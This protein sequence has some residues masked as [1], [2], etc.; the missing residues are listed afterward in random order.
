[1][2]LLELLSPLWYLFASNALLFG[3]ARNVYTGDFIFDF[4]EK[5]N[6]IHHVKSARRIL[7]FF[8]SYFPA[9]KLNTE[10]YSVNLWIQ[11]E[12][13]KIWKIL[14]RSAYH[15]AC[16]KRLGAY[17]ISPLLGK[18]FIRKEHLF[19]GVLIKKSVIS[20][21]D[22]VAFFMVLLDIFYILLLF[23]GS[24]NLIYVT[25]AIFLGNSKM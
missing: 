10:I 4:C 16:I 3:T 15:K 9:F 8:G 14:L 6:A 1:M 5:K 17:L 2:N 11:S 21:S 12:F 20:E 19:Q 13:E 24:L 25:R 23:Y 22:S 7:S 18:P